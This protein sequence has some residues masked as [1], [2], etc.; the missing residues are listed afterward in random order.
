M[1][2]FFFLKWLNSTLS[3]RSA[4]GPTLAT[5][6]F[7]PLYT[8]RLVFSFKNCKL[9]IKVASLYIPNIFV[10]TSLNQ[11]LHAPPLAWF[12]VSTDL[13]RL[14]FPSVTIDFPALAI[15][16][17]SWLT[18]FWKGEE[19]SNE[20]QAPK[21]HTHPH[22]RP[23]LFLA[24]WPNWATEKVLKRQAGIVLFHSGLNR[25]VFFLFPFI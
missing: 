1:L 25:W 7:K 22:R 19:G 24:H 15:T 11:K 4:Q 17:H 3:L 2:R 6:S 10:Y 14:L 5:K 9:V 8:A 12:Y 21:H 20:E 13:F 16:L 23:G 18:P